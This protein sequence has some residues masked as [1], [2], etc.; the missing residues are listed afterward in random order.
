MHRRL[1]SGTLATALAASVGVALLSG[2]DQPVKADPYPH[3][4]R[5][6]GPPLQPFADR[7][8]VRIGHRV[9]VLGDREGAVYH[10][11]TGDWHHFRTP[12]QVTGRDRVVSAGGVAIID[13]D[14]VGRP[15]SWW[16]YDARDGIWSRLRHHPSRLGAPSAFGSE[17]Y[18]LYGRRVV[19][20]SVHLSGWT[21]LPADR[22]RPVLHP[23][24]VTAGASGT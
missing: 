18:A 21:R 12:V 7:I 20:H 24:G 14:R 23:R 2:S 3:W 13:H 17:V 16:S 8:G 10:L 9:L 5:L 22:L 1:V 6:P 4:Q 11:R 19:V 15:A